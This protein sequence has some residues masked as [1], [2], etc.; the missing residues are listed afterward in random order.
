MSILNY[1]I[2]LILRLKHSRKSFQMKSKHLRK[3]HSNLTTEVTII[4]KRQKNLKWI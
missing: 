4:E 2:N 3:S 1:L